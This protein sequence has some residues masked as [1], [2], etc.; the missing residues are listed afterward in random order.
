M[1]S[2]YNESEADDYSPANLIARLLHG[3]SPDDPTLTEYERS[4][5]RGL[6]NL[7]EVRARAAREGWQGLT[8]WLPEP[9]RK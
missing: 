3:R 9:Y 8:H 7:A 1:T 6:R 2:K 4:T 5:I